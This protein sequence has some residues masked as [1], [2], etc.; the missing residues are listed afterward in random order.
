MSGRWICPGVKVICKA[1][2]S[3]AEVGIAVRIKM[4]QEGAGRDFRDLDDDQKSPLE[5]LWA[6]PGKRFDLFIGAALW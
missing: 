2:Q 1:R 4:Q 5:Y 3:K 6:D